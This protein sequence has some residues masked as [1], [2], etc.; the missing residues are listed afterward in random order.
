VYNASKEARSREERVLSAED[1]TE[2]CR[3]YKDKRTKLQ[4]R[5][6]YHALILVTQGYT[7]D[8]VGRSLLLTEEAIRQWV[9][10]YES[11]GLE[12]RQNPSSWGGEHGQRCLNT[13]HLAELQQLLQREARPGTQVGSGWTGEAIRQGIRER[14]G[15]SYSKS[16][17]RKLLPLIGWSYQRGRKLY[18]RRRPEEQARFLLET[19]AT[20]AQYAASGEPVVP[21]A[22]DQSK[23]YLEGPLAR[24]W[25]PIGQQPLVADGARSKKAE[26]I[27][28]AIHLGTGEE[29]S[30]FVIDW[31]DSEATR[32]WLELIL[33]DHPH[34]Q[35]L[36]WLDQAPHHTSDEVE[37]WLAAHPRL[38]VIHFPAYTPEENPKEPTW[39]AL[40]EEVSHHY[41][42]ETFAD[43]S[44]AIDT[45]Y[46]TVKTHTVNFLKKFGYGWS[47][48]RLYALAS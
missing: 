2:A 7:Y 22:G 45:Y 42:H 28:G 35:S 29:V 33:E 18:V 21:L 9:M 11:H 40:K 17:V 19:E 23:V 43:L 16:G 36:W 47:A 5:H 30:S 25:N 32:R 1:Y 12:G 26:N 4:E 3:R 15:V 39:K 48:G 27:Y 34:G 31:Q 37:E 24:R 46:Q 14:F 41:W 8:E 20:L 13:E 6:H 10:R 38:T 44:R